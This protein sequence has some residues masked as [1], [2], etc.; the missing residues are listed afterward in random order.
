MTSPLEATFNLLATRKTKEAQ[1]LLIAAVDVPVGSIQAMAVRYLLRLHQLPSQLLIIRKWSE[2]HP[3]AQEV[4]FEEKHTIR[5]TIKHCLERDD[6]ELR[7]LALEIS[8]S[9]SDFTQIPMILDLMETATGKQLSKLTHA[10]R[11]LTDK[12]YDALNKLETEQEAFSLNTESLSFQLKTV[13]QKISGMIPRLENFEEPDLI[14]ESLLILGSPQ[15]PNLRELMATRDSSL[16]K[17]IEKI[18]L[19]SKHP[20]VMRFIFDSMNLKEPNF[21]IFDAIRTRTDPEFINFLL[22][23][24]PEKPNAIQSDNFKQMQSL[25]W[26]SWPEEELP[27]IL[28]AHQLALIRLLMAVKLPVGL[29]VDILRWLINN[30]TPEVRL[31]ATEV[32]TTLDQRSAEKLIDQ[33]LESDDPEVQAWATSQLRSQAGASA[34]EKLIKR[35]DSDMPEVQAAARQELESFDLDLMIKI[36]EDTPPKAV[37]EAGGLLQKLDVDLNRKLAER[38][39][40]PMASKRLRTAKAAYALGLH[41]NVSQSLIGLLGDPDQMVRRTAVEILGDV[42]KRNVYDM[43]YQMRNDQS[44]RVR[45]AILKSLQRIQME[46]QRMKSEEMSNRSKG[47]LDRLAEAEMSQA[48]AAAGDRE[49]T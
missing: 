3:K 43:L 9:I 47:I 4:V 16:L 23:V 25:R 32:L 10:H 42:P 5:E 45:E 8:V 28:P 37:R 13:V 46:F 27:L 19:Q 20:G 12:F 14:I 7:E 21:R 35:L 33:S 22:S 34:F 36:F 49:E 40:D 1:D 24:F 2:L 30:S 6:G 48:G 31:A 17:R 39:R 18:L 26:L 38:L 29:Q 44:V 41:R 11:M 15:L